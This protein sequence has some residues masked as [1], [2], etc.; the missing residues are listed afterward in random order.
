M[1][2]REEKRLL[3]LD[4]NGNIPEKFFPTYKGDQGEEGDQG[5]EG[6]AG[7]VGPKGDRGEQG[8]E[9]P[10][11]PVGPTGPKGD[12]GA[13]STVAG[14]KGDTG[15][16]GPIGIPGPQGIRGF[17]GI[18]GEVGPTGPKGD[19]GD[20]G[21]QGIQGVKGDKGDTGETGPKGDKGDTGSA[22]TI[23]GPQGPAGT[24]SVA[25][26]DKERFGV[27]MPNGKET[28]PVGTYYTD[29][30]ATNG[31]IRWY[32]KLGTGN[33]GWRV[34]YGDTGMRNITSL[35]LLPCDRLQVQRI[36][37]QITLVVY[38]IGRTAGWFVNMPDGFRSPGAFIA[39]GV[40]I[41]SDGGDP[42]CGKL[43]FSTGGR[44]EWKPFGN[45]TSKGYGVITGPADTSYDGNAWPTTL[46]GTP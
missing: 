38:G 21:T 18:Q 19:K 33:T 9:G 34:V 40:P 3:T 39:G 4:Q 35:A 20:A 13:D 1:A 10:E 42:T 12:K 46:P 25:P 29:T 30:A 28:A 15:E 26:S 7:P 32:K 27:G 31:A 16:Q 23:P 37:D 45:H 36:G 6:P 5:D 41:L 17:Q 44:F 22:S 43:Q 24:S 2:Y 11:G 14:P 8:P